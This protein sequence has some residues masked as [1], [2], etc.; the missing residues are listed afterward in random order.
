MSDVPRTAGAACARP[1]ATPSPG[2][3]WHVRRDARS[4]QLAAAPR[5]PS[6]RASTPAPPACTPT[7]ASRSPEARHACSDRLRRSRQAGTIAPASVGSSRAGPPAA[8][9]ARR[10][11]VPRST[12]PHGPRWRWSRHRPPRRRPPTA[13]RAG[14]LR[15]P[16]LSR[17]RA[18]RDRPR[19]R[20]FGGPKRQAPRSSERVA[21]RRL[22]GFDDSREARPRVRGEGADLRA[23][24]GERFQRARSPFHPHRVGRTNDPTCGSDG[25][26]THLDGREARSQRLLHL[27]VLLRRRQRNAPEG[28]GEHGPVRARRSAEG[29]RQR[30][31][32]LRGKQ[33]RGVGCGNRGRLPDA[34]ICIGQQ[35][36]NRVEQ[37]RRLESSCRAN[38]GRACAGVRA[39]HALPERRLRWQRQ[40]PRVAHLHHASDERRL[41]RGP[42]RDRQP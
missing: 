15:H 26:R 14:G 24:T 22:W 1:R 10:P 41:G 42:S 20:R 38:G 23:D 9:A 30:I 33:L 11:S 18:P 19:P 3:Q 7:R 32:G 16:R 37:R 39:L 2:S 40:I 8:R 35:R 12:R 21:A 34:G 25:L 28:C 5:L 17:P 6:A 31:D 13:R 4:R 29:L 36:Q 27:A